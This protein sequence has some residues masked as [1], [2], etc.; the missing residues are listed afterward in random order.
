MHVC[1]GV[2][3]CETLQCNNYAELISLVTIITMGDS[4]SYKVNAHRQLWGYVQCG[5]V[6]YLDSLIPTKVPIVL[7]FC[8]ICN[9]T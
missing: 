1:V 4:T 9:C 5:I 8:V 2:V 3:L 7:V 6:S